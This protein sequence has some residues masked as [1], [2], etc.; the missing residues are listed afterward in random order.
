[1]YLRFILFIKQ[2]QLALSESLCFFFRKS[3]CLMSAV[4]VC[5]C[6]AGGVQSHW[7]HHHQR[8]H[9]LLQTGA[10]SGYSAPVPVLA[11]SRR[12]LRSIWSLRAAAQ[13]PD[14]SG[15]QLQPQ[16]HPLQCWL[17][18]NRGH[19]CFGPNLPPAA[20]QAADGRLQHHEAGARSEAT[21]TQCRPDQ[22][23]V[24]VHLQSNLLFVPTVSSEELFTNLLQRLRGTALPLH[25][26]ERTGSCR[27]RCEGLT[28]SKQ[29]LHQV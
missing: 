13:S 6:P 22:R 19:L 14:C 20:Q 17:W 12:S 4:R 8:V 11:R 29:G 26:T 1:M 18:P 7:G 24:S 23:A 2:H 16:T 3:F 9:C 27:G 28:R 21:E 5:V 10:A 25:Y 15:K